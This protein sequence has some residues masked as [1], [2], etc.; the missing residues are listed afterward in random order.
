[1]ASLISDMRRRIRNVPTSAQLAAT[2]E[3]I[4]I[5][6]IWACVTCVLLQLDLALSDA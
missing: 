5:I 4:R 1:M 6:S 3:A 2:V